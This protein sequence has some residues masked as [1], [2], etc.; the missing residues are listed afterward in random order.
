MSAEQAVK[1]LLALDANRLLGY[2]ANMMS[3]VLIIKRRI[4]FGD[5]D[6][7]EAVVWKVPSPVP[8]TE[9]GFKYRLVYIVDGR[10][11]IGFDN[12]RGRGDHRHDGDQVNEYRFESVDALLNDFAEAIERWRIEH[13]KG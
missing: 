11:V 7:A 9:H 3:A 4:V 8:P 13:G 6:F 1:R 10:R 12:E 5:R 2:D